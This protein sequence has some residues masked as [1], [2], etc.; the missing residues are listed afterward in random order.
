LAKR[1]DRTDQ[2]LMLKL[3][4]ELPFGQMDARNEDVKKLASLL[5]RSPNSVAMKLA[6]YASLDETLDRK[7][8]D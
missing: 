5:G 7:G 6:N 2:V 3:C 4:T 8:L 1:W